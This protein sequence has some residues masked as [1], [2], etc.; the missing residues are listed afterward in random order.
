MV[1]F[2]VV[3]NVKCADPGSGSLKDG[4]AGQYSTSDQ[5]VLHCRCS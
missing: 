4:D 1:V 2:F 5:V 3:Y